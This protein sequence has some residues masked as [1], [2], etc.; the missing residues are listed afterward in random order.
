MRYTFCTSVALSP[1]DSC[2]NGAAVLGAELKTIGLDCDKQ[3]IASIVKG[4][5]SYAPLQQSE[6]F[7]KSAHTLI[8]TT[9]QS[10]RQKDSKAAQKGLREN[11]NLAA[12]YEAYGAVVAPQLESI[13]GVR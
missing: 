4:I 1:F 10:L 5:E 7:Q 11:Q 2:S 13:W 9:I 8:N 12:F 3:S 6:A